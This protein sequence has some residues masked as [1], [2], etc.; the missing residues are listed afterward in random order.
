MTT[1]ATHVQLELARPAWL[2]LCAARINER[3]YIWGACSPHAL[4]SASASCMLLVWENTHHR[5]LS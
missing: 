1:T 3:V 4:A 2:Q 5:S